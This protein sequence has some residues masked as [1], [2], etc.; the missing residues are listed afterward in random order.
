MPLLNNSSFDPN[1][2]SMYFFQGISCLSLCGLNL[3][4]LFFGYLLTSVYAGLYHHLSLALPLR[5]YRVTGQLTTIPVIS[6]TIE[7][8]VQARS[9]G[10]DVWHQTSVVTVKHKVT[11][12]GIKFHLEV[13][14]KRRFGYGTVVHL[15][16]AKNCHHTLADRHS[17]VA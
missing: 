16:V 15:C 14:Y 7:N 5:L 6:K 4:F 3:P 1:S 2:S 8:Y 11:Y 12:S 17:G 13:T 9:M 10:A